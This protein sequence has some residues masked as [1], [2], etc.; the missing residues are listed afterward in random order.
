MI[1]VRKDNRGRILLPGEAQIKNG[2]YTYRYTDPNGVRRSVSNWRLLPGDPAPDGVTNPECLRDVENRILATRR[3]HVKVP[4]KEKNTLNDFWQ[5]YLSMKCEIAETTLVHYIQVYNKH[6]KDEFGKRP[7]QSI[8]YS[9]LKRF[10]IRKIKEGMGLSTLTN[11]NNVLNPI[12]AMAYREGYLDMNPAEGLIGELRRRKDWKETH[13][14]ALTEEEQNALVDYASS[15]IEYRNMLPMITLMLGTGIRCGEM[16]GLRWDDVDFTRNVISVNH[17]MNYAVALDG[18]S[19]YIITVPKTKNAEREIP[20]LNDVRESLLELYDRRMDYNADNQAVV[21]GYTNFIFRDLYGCVYN[22]RRINEMLKRLTRDY[23]L[24]E[25]ERALEEE[26]E[27]M[28]LPNI[29]C[30]NLRHTFCSNLILN[31]VNV[32]TVQ[33]LMGHAYA[34]TTLRIYTNITL[35]HNMDE[36]KTLEGKIRLR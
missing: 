4:A 7:I 33:L 29:S 3:R 32:K 2:S 22:N 17:T 6:V 16:L 26:R 1:K 10:Y 28:L 8:R 20:M 27:P 25:Q 24:M 35:K 11:L 13:R 36:L 23:N 19:H 21:D 12:F 9:D 5:L 34:E 14:A 18:K 15:A 31:G 30:H